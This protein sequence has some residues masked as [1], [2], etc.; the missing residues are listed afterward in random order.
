MVVPGSVYGFGSMGEFMTGG[1]VWLIQIP[2]A[3]AHVSNSFW[4]L[5]FFFFPLASPCGL[6]CRQDR[7]VFG[8]LIYQD[9]SFHAAASYELYWVDFTSAKKIIQDRG[10]YTK[11]RKFCKYRQL[12]WKEVQCSYLLL[13]F[14][15]SLAHES[16]Q[17][18][19]TIFESRIMPSRGVCVCVPILHT[20]ERPILCTPTIIFARTHLWHFPLNSVGSISQNLN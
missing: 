15:T 18:A 12:W 14:V 8:Q 9:G 5:S 2:I 7:P 10:P 4:P 11:S 17:G 1:W 3:K 20:S 19:I 6:R 16:S 13:L